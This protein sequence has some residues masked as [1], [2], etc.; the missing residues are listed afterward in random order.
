MVSAVG[1]AIYRDTSAQMGWP[2]VQGVVEQV[3]LQRFERAK[4]RTERAT[5]RWR[6][7]LRYRYEVAGTRYT[8]ERYSSSPPTSDADGGRQ[9]SAELTALLERHGVGSSVEVFYSPVDPREAVLSPS[10]TA[11]GYVLAVG[12]ALLL[13]GFSAA[14]A[15]SRRAAR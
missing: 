15:F 7:Q 14:F 1:W 4:T 8:S 5:M 11:N 3:S 2:Q 10:T 13:A 12:I 6:L 9:P